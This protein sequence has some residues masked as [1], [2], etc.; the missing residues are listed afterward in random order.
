MASTVNDVVVQCEL[1]VRAAGSAK[2]AKPTNRKTAWATPCML[3]A[4]ARRL[5]RAPRPCRARTAP[6]RRSAGRWCPSSQRRTPRCTRGARSLFRFRTR[7][8]E[9]GACATRHA[10]LGRTQRPARRGARCCMRCLAAWAPRAAEAST[11]RSALHARGAQNGYRMLTRRS[12]F[13][14]PFLA[15]RCEQE[16]A[17][18]RGEEGAQEV[19][20][21]LL[22]PPACTLASRDA[23][24]RPVPTRMGRAAAARTHA[25]RAPPWLRRHA[26]YTHTRTRRRGRSAY[27]RPQAS[28]CNN[29]GRF[30]L[31]WPLGSS[32]TVPLGP[33][34]AAPRAAYSLSPARLLPQPLCARAESPLR[35][36]LP[37]PA[38]PDAHPLPPPR[39]A[40]CWPS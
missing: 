40:A 2:C 18:G 23:A 22:K 9:N 17:A 16:A 5:T 10:R 36:L 26:L 33:S 27:P 19:P 20:G 13:L 8:P 30:S 24:P 34:A 21:H 4:H 37:V 38:A 39:A 14:S 12:V 15:Q 35:W 7:Y 25:A 32:V 6:R 31:W 3:P 29:I 11:A 1:A 28:R